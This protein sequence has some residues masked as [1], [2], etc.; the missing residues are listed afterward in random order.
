MAFTP[1]EEETLKKVVDAFNNGKRLSELPEVGDTNPYN[2]VVEVLENGESKQ[3]KLAA[4]LPYLED[5]CSYGVEFDTAVSSPTCKRIGNMELHKSLPVQSLMRG[6]TLGDDGQVVDYLPANDWTGA[7]RDGSRGQVMVELPLYYRK[8]ETDGTKRRVRISLLPLAGYDQVPKKY[9][10][11]YPAALDRSGQKLASVVNTSAQYRGGNNN[12]AYDGTCRSFLGKAVTA[13]SR[14]NFRKYARNRGA[15]GKN[16]C[17]WNCMT[18]DIAKDIYW[19]FVVEYATLNS[20]APYNAELSPEG[21][22]QGGLGAGVTSVGSPIGEGKEHNGAPTESWAVFNGYYPWVP[23]GHSD[24]LGNNTGQ[25][26]C[27]VQDTDTQAWLDEFVPRY[28]GIENPFG[29]IWHWTDGINVR[30]N[31]TEEN[32]GNNKSEIFICE[33]PAKFTDSNYEG[34]SFVGLEARNEGYTKELVFGKG[35]EIMPAV[36]G[37]GAGSTTYHCDYHYTNIPSVTT[38]RGVLFGGNS[39]HGTSAG[40]VCSYSNSA[41][42][43]ANAYFGSR[44]CFLP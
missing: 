12:D 16:G 5:E 24:S 43:Y 40:L 2:L 17:G 31:P 29:H 3:S 10:S 30:I 33:D 15:A 23:C 28:R 39:S 20:Q 14:T 41:P 9:V 6:C 42:S 21:Y 26:E 34:Y 4:L 25:V 35:G 13:T 18:Y 19:L 22:R 7:V 1:Q 27:S 38:L 44:L 32:N 8:F 37:G 36:C 11:A